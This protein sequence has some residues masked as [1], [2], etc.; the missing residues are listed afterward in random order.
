MQVRSNLFRKKTHPPKIEETSGKTTEEG[1]I[2]QEGQTW[3][4]YVYKTT[5]NTNNND[6]I[7]DTCR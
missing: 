3:N 7:S 5:V 6:I 2:S 4:R 1:S